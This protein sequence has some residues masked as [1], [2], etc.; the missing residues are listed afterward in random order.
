MKICLKCGSDK[1]YI[2]KS[3][4]WK[5]YEQ[6]HKYEDGWICSKCYDKLIH[7]PKQHLIDNPRRMR[8]KGKHIMLKQNPRTGICSK[9]GKKGLTHIHHIEYHDD[10]PL[11]DTIELCVGCHN[12]QRL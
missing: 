6:W 1:T 7:H 10:N 8:F 11:K 4:R 12:K 3:H 2:N 9:C 5:P